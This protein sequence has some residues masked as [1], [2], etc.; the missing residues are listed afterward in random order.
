MSMAAPVFFKG[1]DTIGSSPV[2]SAVRLFRLFGAAVDAVDLSGCEPDDLVEL[3]AGVREGQQALDR[4]MVFVALVAGQHALESKGR[5]VVGTLLGDGRRVRGRTAHAEAERARTV[6]KFRRLEVAVHAGLVGA[7]QIDAISAAIRGLSDD[8]QQSLAADE[9]IEAAL[10][11][12][13]DVFAKHVRREAELIKGDNG[14][15]DT[16][17]R[18]ARSSWKHW[19]DERTGM[20][21]VH[22]EFDPERYEA[23]IGSV[24]AEL[25][26]LANEGGVSKDCHLAAEA[27]CGLL[28]GR[29]RQ[30]RSGRPHISVVV[31]WETAPH[32]RMGARRLHRSVQSGSLV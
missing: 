3:V 2:L 11:L 16:K 26:R 17:R 13:A 15:A 8:D 9:L 5:G 23:I 25:T 14:L 21:H 4:V 32:S 22:G 10:S 31:D 28:S 6:S 12:P 18:Q 27:A 24:E 29:Q 19:F 20:G 30:S 7:A 1:G